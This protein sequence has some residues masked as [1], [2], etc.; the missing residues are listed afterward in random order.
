MVKE[1]P[2]LGVHWNNQ[3]RSPVRFS[4]YR[5]TPSGN[6]QLYLPGHEKS[7]VQADV[8]FPDGKKDVVQFNRDGQY[9]RAKRELPLGSLYQ[10]QVD[11]KP[12]LDLLET[13]EFCNKAYNVTSPLERTA[14]KKSVVIADLF[15][16]GAVADECLRAYQKTGI[17]AR[18]HFNDF[19]GDE[20]GLKSLVPLLQEAGY[21]ALLFKPFIGG[22]NLSSHGY[23]TV[24]PFA[25]NKSFS[26]KKAFKNSLNLLLKSGMK[27]FADG[28]FVNQ[29]L[30]GIQYL[31]NLH[32]GF[33]SPFW[34]WFTFEETNQKGQSQYPRNAYEGMTLGI[35]PTKTDPMSR[36][37]F[38]DYDRFDIRVLND[39]AQP[40]YSPKKPTFI[41][42]FN[43]QTADQLLPQTNRDGKILS[44]EDSV[45]TYRFP[46][47]VKELMEK[48]ERLEQLKKAPDYTDRTRKQLLSEWK[49]FRLGPPAEDDSSL[50]WDGQIDVAKMNMRNPEVQKFVEDSMVYWTRFVKNTYTETVASALQKARLKYPDKSPLEL[51]Q[52]I[53]ATTPQDARMPGKV[54]PPIDFPQL[55][56]LTEADVEKALTSAVLS[57]TKQPGHALAETILKQY[58]LPVLP[59]PPL[60][61]AALTYPELAKALSRPAA[62]WLMQVIDFAFKPLKMLAEVAPKWRRHIDSWVDFVFEKLKQ[63]SFE[64]MLANKLER[65]IQHLSRDAQQK[66][67]SQPVRELIT[68]TVA[69]TLYLQ[70]L[71][72]Q[73]STVP[74]NV[75]EGFYRT[76]PDYIAQA[77]PQ[78][79]ANLLPRFLKDRLKALKTNQ[80]A[81]LIER[82][83]RDLEPDMVA[84]ASAVLD[85]REFGLNWRIDAAK[86][87]GDMDLVRNAPAD[88]RKDLFRQEMSFVE[89]FWKQRGEAIRNVSPK[90]AIIAELTD[91]EAL[92]DDST[93]RNISRRLFDVFNGIPNMR[94]MY[95]SLA[96]AV[97]MVQN[98]AEFGGDLQMKPSGFLN[99]VK[100]M[101]QSVPLP[102]LR[103]YQNMSSSHDYPT[104]SHTF[105]M[106]PDIFNMDYI[107]WWGIQ[108]YF[109]EAVSE[110]LTKPGFQRERELL[111]R[112][113]VENLKEIFATLNTA[114]EKAHQQKQFSPSVQNYFSK[115]SKQREEPVPLDAKQNF[116][117][118]LFTLVTPQQLGVDPRT[119]N[120]LRTVLSDRILEPS[121]ARAMRGVIQNG[122]LR[123]DWTGYAR[124]I[125]TQVPPKQ[126]Q[127][128]FFSLFSEA[129]QRCVQEYGSH[130]GY[131][132]LYE[133]L[134]HVL[135]NLDDT[136]L[137][138]LIPGEAPTSLVKQ[139]LHEQ[140]FD[141]LQKPV[142]E[143]KFLRKVALQVG[144]PGNPSIYEIVP[145][146][147]SESR[148]NKYVQNRP[149]IRYDWLKERPLYQDY[150]QKLSRL[151]HLRKQ[152][153]VLN[154]GIVLPLQTQDVDGIVPLVRDNG[155]E[156]AIMLV[157][158]GKPSLP[159]DYPHWRNLTG[160]DAQY[161]EIQTT[162]KVKK[163]FKLNLSAI[164]P[165]PEKTVYRDVETGERFK[166]DKN[167]QLVSLDNPGRGM[168]IEV[169]RCLVR[170]DV[171]GNS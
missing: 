8:I 75:E 167:Y 103:Q 2:M 35:L 26:N 152:V 84:V 4:G 62:P 148:K 162:Q 141:Q 139:T 78:T 166:V 104:A 133:A 66:L 131:Q 138:Q 169:Y 79:A 121:E 160:N 128:G 20:R 140:L 14:P 90:T 25:L 55:E 16:N 134:H 39:P 6:A 53:T 45:Q 142:L 67:R 113:G 127:E 164:Q 154:D 12:E 155:R 157:N 144:V 5:L 81:Q 163:N 23:W 107:R 112:E 51:V 10:I 61:K 74:D 1:I 89:G 31:A 130:F 41:E 43:P 29:G 123:F 145:Q 118:E 58:P 100:G 56:T 143:D 68:E 146:G 11:G 94:Y 93:A 108:E 158:T 36:I 57:D 147:G 28:A 15:Q 18:N 150:H 59:M 24:D 159:E 27:P 170:E 99:E 156:Q 17:P 105:L 49:Q 125:N 3:L 171:A 7:R 42:L 46:V 161:P 135:E 117:D 115:G 149:L 165:Q 98:P 69:Q 52:Q 47:P 97:H 85:K 92:S 13:R 64:G 70:L 122:M 110:L 151:L 38:V 168:D 91:F 22:D 48:Q 136:A 119:F 54:L 65:S 109:N 106:N 102:A 83:L 50:K 126:L 37:R 30:N 86:D 101:S 116:V 44:S 73:T 32:Y 153:P 63:F 129:I 71:T 96:K 9:W 21:S 82:Q 95:S 120:A 137:K 34:D 88:K 60:F 80:I 72:G 76:V 132:P 114:A 33:R 87:V 111:R 124:A 40:E 77:D 19:G